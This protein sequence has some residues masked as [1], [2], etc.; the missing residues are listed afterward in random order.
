MSKQHYREN[1]WNHLENNNLSDNPTPV[2]GRIPNFKQSQIAANKLLELEEFQK[3]K[4]IEI[5]PDKP[6]EAARFIAL[7]NEKDL[8]VPIPRLRNGFLKHFTISDNTNDKIIK[9]LIS[10]KGLEYKGT[11]IDIKDPLKIDLLVVGSV[12]VSKTGQ[13]I[14]KGRGYADLEYAILTELKAVNSETVIVT[15]V[16]DSQVQYR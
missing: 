1:V 2:R 16:E 4:C 15:N 11:I 9:R 8:Y 12:A 7:K 14:G 5:N 3:A 6:Q 13:R 10:R